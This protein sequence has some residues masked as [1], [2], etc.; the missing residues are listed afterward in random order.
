MKNKVNIKE[1]L[2]LA[3]TYISVCI[4]SG[5]ATGQ[6]IM[7][8]FSA[9]GMISI[10]SNTI[11]MGIMAYCG[12]SLLEIGNKK[13]LKSSNDIFEYLCGKHIG[14]L[15]KRFMPIF[16]FC[17]FVIMLSGA[18][19]SI[20]QY[21]GISKNLGSLILAIITL[22]SVLLGINKV[23]S[24]L[25][26]IG[27]IIAVISIGVGIVTISRNIDSFCMA[28]EII[29]TLNLT[30]AVDNWWMTAIIYSGLNLVIATPFLVGVGATATNKTNCIWGGILGGIVFMIL[31]TTSLP[32]YPM[33]HIVSL[34]SF[35]YHGTMVYLGILINI[36]H[37]I[38]LNASDIRYYAG[39]VGIVCVLAYIINEVFDCN[40]MFISKNFPGTPLEILYNITGPFYTIIMSI[41]QMTLPFYIIR[42]GKNVPG[43][44]CPVGKNV[45]GTKLTK[46][47]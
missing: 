9:H 3:G 37:Y 6:E 45:P 4:G 17:S 5:F 25:G 34:H 27:P 33:L 18:G 43:T 12:A 21:Y 2:T 15:F 46:E 28:N 32:A 31:P 40:L 36:T 35:L 13:N 42:W 23:I 14:Y 1:I 16:F 20:N 10:L 29:G 19:A 8:F 39:L 7:Q 30:K 24:I 38:E 11:C 41:A 22:C 47:A 44:K 26:N